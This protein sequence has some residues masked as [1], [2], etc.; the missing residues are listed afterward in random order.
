MQDQ[1]PKQNNPYLA[2][3]QRKT[4]TSHGNKAEKN[5]A[6]RL[7]AKLTPASGAMAGAKG[8]MEK[9]GFRI[10]S[11]ATKAES[12]RLELGWL[13][14]IYQEAL[15]RGENPALIVQFV[16]SDGKPLPRG[17]WVMVPEDLFKEFIGD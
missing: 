3:Q 17:S 13:Q 10:E 7:K 8:D 14:K 11:K 2:R 9:G 4:K 6:Q 16:N 15:E 1:T 5:V 12:M